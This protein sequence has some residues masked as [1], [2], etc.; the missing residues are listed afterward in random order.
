MGALS[1]VLLVLGILMLLEGAFAVLF[2]KTAKKASRLFIRLFKVV[3]NHLRA[4]GTI[5]III[6]IILIMISQRV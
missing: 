3:E 2:T 1:I 4:W 6:A 5:E